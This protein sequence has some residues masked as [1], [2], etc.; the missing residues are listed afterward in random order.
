MIKKACSLYSGSNLAH[1]QF[2]INF[3]PIFN[4]K[5]LTTMTHSR[6]FPNGQTD[7]HWYDLS[8]VIIKTRGKVRIVMMLI[9]VFVL[10]IYFLS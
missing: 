9:D 5:F 3:F 2:W 1:P 4:G 10:V 6:S 8:L 7:L